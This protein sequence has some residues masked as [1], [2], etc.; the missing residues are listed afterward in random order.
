MRFDFRRVTGFVELW[1]PILP[2]CWYVCAGAD[3]VKVVVC[4]YINSNVV[5]VSTYCSL[6]LV[7]KCRLFYLLREISAVI[8]NVAY[9]PPQDKKITSWHKA[10]NKLE[11]LHPEAAFL[12]SGNFNYASLRHLMLNIHQH[13]SDATRGDKALGVNV[14]MQVTENSF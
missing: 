11:N 14:V 4:L 13:V 12:V 3:G 9:I 6:L 5:E 10:I 8:V 1:C 7:V 2:G